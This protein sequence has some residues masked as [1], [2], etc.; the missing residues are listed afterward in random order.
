MKIQRPKRITTQGITE[1]SKEAVTA[2]GSAAN[3]FIEEVYLAIMGKITISDNLDQRFQQVKVNV[4]ANGIPNTRVQF[5]ANLSGKT[6]GITCIRAF[7]TSYVNSAPFVSF[8]DNSGIV[9]INH[10]SG[11]I[12]DTDYT[13]VLILIGD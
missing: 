1:E 4:D 5:N 11:L 2:V 13:L 12:A 3:T 7:G 10:V 6:N 9:T 8:T